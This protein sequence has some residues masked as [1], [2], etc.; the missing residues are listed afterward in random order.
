MINLLLLLTAL[1]MF[2]MVAAWVAEN[3]GLVTIVW[4]SWRI[5][6]SFAFLMFA[7]CFSALLVAVVFTVIRTIIKTPEEWS[8]KR[9]LKYQRKGLTELT[10]SVASLAASDISGAEAHTRKAE[11]LLGKTPIT[12]LLSAQI[13]R[14]RGDD[15]KTKLLLE[16]LLEHKETEY[17][18][19]RSLSDAATKQN[20]LPQALDLAKRAH[21]INPKD[22]SS[23]AA[24]VSLNIKLSQ[25]QEAL[26]A[27]DQN[28]HKGLMQRADMLRLRG[29]THFMYAQSLMEQNRAEEAL[30]QAIMAR[31][32]LGHFVPATSL[33]AKAYAASG[34]SD[35]AIR[36]LF[37]SWQ[38]NKHPQ[39]AA[40]IQGL[41]A[42][43]H[44]KY[45]KILKIVGTNADDLAALWTCSAC[46]HSQPE[47]TLHCPT[48]DGFDTLG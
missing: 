40:M 30:R 41:A 47:W 10:Y 22:S 48:C 2:G 21:S 24:I 29:I 38:K 27:I 19:A 17:L 34:Q 5:D 32:T 4:D 28:A 23:V 31:K 42:S 15:A 16:Q 11:K 9:Q 44:K 18:A 45:A 25:W 26:R 43:N 33:L 7:V 3:P 20:L 1:T 12:L 14:T 8:T 39:L 35:K 13:A 36:M 6:T 46:G 37:K